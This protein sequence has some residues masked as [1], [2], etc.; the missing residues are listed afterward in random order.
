MCDLGIKRDGIVEKVMAERR[1]PVILNE[2]RPST[3]IPATANLR[4]KELQWWRQVKA[5]KNRLDY[6]H[7]GVEP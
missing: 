2:K 5:K 4:E 1:L 6:D 7:L 3:W